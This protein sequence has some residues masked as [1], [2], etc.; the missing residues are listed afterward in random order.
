MRLGRFLPL[1]VAPF[2]FSACAAIPL[3]APG[4]PP[5]EE[6]LQ[7][8]EAREQALQGLKGLDEVKVSS[9]QN[10]LQ[11][12]QVLFARR[13]AF[14]RVETLSPLGTPLLYAVTDGQSLNLYQPGENNYYHGTFRASSLSLALPPDLSPPEVVS[15]LLGGIPER[16][17]EK[18]SIRAER[19]E[20]LWVLELLSPFR[21]ETQTIWV[22]PQF[23]YI[24]R[25]EFN[26]PRFSY[27]VA[28]ADFNPTGGILF[29]KR[30]LLTSA[31]PPTKITVEF[32]EMELNPDW[33]AQDFLLS[34]PR[35]AKVLPLP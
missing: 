3:L 1:L 4:I 19:E 30:M 28:F 2:L 20:G 24:V 26:R 11:G 23:F 32:Q 13:P 34:I 27:R 8:V 9:S 7:R 15:F 12:Q 31:D 29:S 21:K 18:V 17:F 25:A 14:L 6:I 16:D 5:A 22:H 33:K 10:T 35:G